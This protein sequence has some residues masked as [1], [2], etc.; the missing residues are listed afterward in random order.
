[1]RSSKR[2]LREDS[3]HS[4]ASDVFHFNTLRHLDHPNAIV[5]GGFGETS[6]DYT[7]TRNGTLPNCNS[8]KRNGTLPQNGSVHYNKG[9]NS[10]DEVIITDTIKSKAEQAEITFNNHKMQTQGYDNP[11]LS[12]SDSMDSMEKAMLAVR[13]QEAQQ[14]HEDDL[15]N[16]QNDFMFSY[17]NKALATSAIDLNTPVHAPVAVVL[18]NKRP[19]VKEMKSM[20][21]TGSKNEVNHNTLQHKGTNG[22]LKNGL[23]NRYATLPSK[24]DEKPSAQIPP[25]LISEHR[26]AD[27][28]L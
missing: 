23:S 20:F 25:Q 17:D 1:M 24:L 12:K 2:L 7:L 11:S 27:V 5:L 14:Q 21:E 18:P 9:D 10:S 13:Q 19:S 8:F 3:R 28:Q 15:V 22:V 4:T 16:S 26:D 6:T